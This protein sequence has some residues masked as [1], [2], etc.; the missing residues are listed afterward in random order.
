M[1]R[2]DDRRL[3]SALIRGKPRQAGTSGPGS[4]TRIVRRGRLSFHGSRV[5]LSGNGPQ[6]AGVGAGFG[7][8]GQ[9]VA[10]TIE[11]ALVVVPASANSFPPAVVLRP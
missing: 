10:G 4:P 11:L 5:L 8:K 7:A 6:G 1:I 3:S 2:R 9:A